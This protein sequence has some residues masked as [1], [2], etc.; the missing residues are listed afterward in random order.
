MHYTAILTHTQ[1]HILA[2]VRA[3][4]SGNI[5]HEIISTIIHS[6]TAV[7]SRAVAKEYA[8]STG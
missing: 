1:N 5:G 8:L 3:S 6:P 4:G 2:C 7:S